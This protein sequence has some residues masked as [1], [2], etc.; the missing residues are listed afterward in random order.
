MAQSS[1]PVVM[2][3]AWEDL[4]KGFTRL[5]VT[6]SQKSASKQVSMGKNSDLFKKKNPTSLPKSTKHPLCLGHCLCIPHPVSLSDPE[7][8]KASL[9]ALLGSQGRYWAGVGLEAKACRGRGWS[10]EKENSG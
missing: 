1:D 6:L 10:Y 3:H 5:W 2:D 7:D 8:W 4:D 9:G